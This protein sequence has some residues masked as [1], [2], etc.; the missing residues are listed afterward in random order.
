V[1][2]PV[3]F[4]AGVQELLRRG[5]PS[6]IEVGPGRSLSTLARQAGAKTVLPSMTDPGQDTGERS[7]ALE[8]LSRLWVAG[9]TPDW[10][11]LHAGE[12]RHRL[13]LPTYPFERK[14]FWIDPPGP[15]SKTADAVP[16][17]LGEETSSAEL[18]NVIRRQL[19]VLER[20]LQVLAEGTEE[21]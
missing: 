2:H 11:A 5:D 8:A 4:F 16:S 10:A 7:A 17:S 18:Q 21:R 13:S 12:T 20:Q 19:D 6:L 14:R 9:A 3:R 1:R 15:G